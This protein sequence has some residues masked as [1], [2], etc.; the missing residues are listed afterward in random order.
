M[1]YD[2][3]KLASMKKPEADAP[4]ED[5]MFEME[6]AEEMGESIDLS[7][8]SDDEILAEA[9]KRGLMPDEEAAPAGDEMEMEI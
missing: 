9:K 8:V 4:M 6:D 1:A 3:E 5:D 7:A 2:K